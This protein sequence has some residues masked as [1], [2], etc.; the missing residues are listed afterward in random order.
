MYRIIALACLVACGVPAVGTAAKGYAE[1]AVA[2]GTFLIDWRGDFTP[3]Q[4]TKLEIWLNAAGEA[5]ALVHGELPRPVIRIA[6][7]PYPAS[8]AVPF[9]RVLRQDPQGVLFY[10]NPDRP[11]EEFISDWTAY[12]ELAHLFIPYP[13]MPDIWFSEGLASYYQNIVQYRA[14]L[15]TEAQARQ[16][17]LD[18]F[19]RGRLESQHAALTL[20]QLSEEMRERHAYMR[21]YWSGALYFLEA[22]LALRDATRSD[23][24]FNS[25]DAVLHE[26]GNCCVRTT[27]RR[28]GRQIAAEFDRIARTSLFVPLYDNYAASLEIPDYQRFSDSI[29]A[30]TV[31]ER[32]PR[33]EEL[34]VQ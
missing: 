3:E 21:V 20:T 34:A 16:K 32:K 30:D 33:N 28:T 29:R 18:G 9:A 23:Q 14:G 31:L 26:Y 19:E 24:Q 11:L 7:Q 25:L 17:L 1:L 4:Q 13:G 10:I 15:L 22:D 2:D 5:I 27:G 8:T 6:M 12:H